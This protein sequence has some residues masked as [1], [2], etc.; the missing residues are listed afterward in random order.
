MN[1]DFVDEFRYASP[2]WLKPESE[3]DYVAMIRIAYA[4]A[5]ITSAEQ[6]DPQKEAR[7]T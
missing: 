7:E 5:G 1:K 2:E 4:L 3:E 6:V